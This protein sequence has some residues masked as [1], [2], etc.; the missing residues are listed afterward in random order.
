MCSHCSNQKTA[1][2]AKSL[3]VSTLISSFVSIAG[4]YT[5]S[6]FFSFFFIRA[7]IIKLVT[8]AAVPPLPITPITM[9]VVAD[10]EVD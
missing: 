9:P 5:C 10:E 4:P 2:D 8:K 6:S 3:S 1:F 7:F